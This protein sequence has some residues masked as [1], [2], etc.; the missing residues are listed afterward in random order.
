L[1]LLASFIHYFLN[2][3]LLHFFFKGCIGVGRISCISWALH[4]VS[5][6]SMENVE[7]YILH[8]LFFD[9]S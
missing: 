3:K 6:T 7:I 9:C 2:D 1:N 4:D 8:Y 5:S